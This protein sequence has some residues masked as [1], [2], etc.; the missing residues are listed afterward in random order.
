MDLQRATLKALFYDYPVEHFIH[1]LLEQS[2]RGF[3]EPITG[4]VQW[5][6]L[7][8]TQSELQA[9]CNSVFLSHGTLSDTDEQIVE[10]FKLLKRYADSVLCY[11]GNHAWVE[12]KQLFRWRELS[13]CIGEDTLI[14]P[15]LAEKDDLHNIERQCFTWPDILPH[16]NHAINHLFDEGISDLHAHLFASGNIAE[17]NWISLMNR[18]DYI[19]QFKSMHRMLEIPILQY[20][21]EKELELKYLCILAAYIRVQLFQY[22]RHPSSVSA[23][24]MKSALNDL[25]DETLF[26]DLKETTK[27]EIALCGTEALCTRFFEKVDY[28]IISQEYSEKEL[29]S[30]Y[31]L[32]SGERRILYDYFLQ[33]QRKPHEVRWFA[34]YVYLYILIKIRFRRELIQTNQ[35]LGFQNFSHYQSRKI[36]FLPQKERWREKFMAIFAIQS[37]LRSS[38][39]HIEVRV[40][41]A[42]LSFLAQLDFSTAFFDADTSLWKDCQV[43]VVVHFSKSAANHSRAD[44]EKHILPY[45]EASRKTPFKLV[46]LDAAGSEFSARPEDFGPVFRYAKL[47]KIER[48]T[49]HA[50]EDFYDITDGLRTMD[51]AVLFLHLTQGDRLGHGLA[52]GLDAWSFYECRHFTVA[53]PQM[54]LLDNLV[55]IYYKAQQYNI[56]IEPSVFMFIQEKCFALYQELYNRDNF[57]FFHYWNSML[58]RSNQQESNK[59]SF[60]SWQAAAC[61]TNE[62]CLLAAKDKTALQ[63]FSNYQEKKKKRQTIS[64]KFPRGYAEL[65]VLVQESLQSE[66]AD[67]GIAIECNPSSNLKIGRFQKYEDHPIFR[68]SPPDAQSSDLPVLQVSVCTDDRGVFSTSLQN[69]FS[70]LALSMAKQ[71]TVDG[72]RKWSDEIIGEYIQKLIKK[73]HDQRF[74]KHY[75]TNCY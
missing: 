53:I 34:P 20:Q 35:L 51:E 71:R 36:D 67:R 46:G 61:C 16:N 65:V 28:A 12:F 24:E 8:F 57:D 6:E 33:L 15:F 41:P 52:L 48:A 29:S 1:L 17:L 59:H 45:V 43:D 30:P 39:D 27:E 13:L 68:F 40:L 4:L 3:T 2:E 25:K 70:L 56:S 58:L 54:I 75:E 7:S 11:E 21:G 69:E 73:G 63:M 66:F 74:R 10:V 32:L 38:N 60:T 23:Q 9:W 44:L 14:L 31:M 22:L 26:N 42:M 72:K 18:L 47:M 49:F 50:G 64:C 5:R 62:R 19:N 37:C 55:W